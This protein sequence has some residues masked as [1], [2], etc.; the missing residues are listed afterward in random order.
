VNAAAEDLNASYR[1]ALKKLI[2]TERKLS[3]VNVI[4]Q[5]LSEEVNSE[6]H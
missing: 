3:A 2:E 6:P 5:E 1:K 4:A